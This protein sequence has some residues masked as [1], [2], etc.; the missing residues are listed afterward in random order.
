MRSIRKGVFLSALECPAKGWK[1]YHGLDAPGLSLCDEFRMRQG[2]E[3]GRRAR[4]LFPDG[5]LV[6][7]AHPDQ[8]LR[9]TRAIL[10]SQERDT[11][12]EAMA[13]HG[14]LT[15]RADILT[16]QGDGWRL[17]EVKSALSDKAEYQAD[18]AYSVMVF[19]NSGLNIDRASLLL[20]S[21]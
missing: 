1:L 16:W 15:A 9:R 4:Q 3:I 19:R 20:I 13:R 8:A 10:E 5:V 2:Q 21:K 11:I 18:L 6:A 7:E 14:A 12:F 17:I